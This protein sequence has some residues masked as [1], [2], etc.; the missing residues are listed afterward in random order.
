YNDE[1]T[2]SYSATHTGDT[3]Y[4]LDPAIKDEAK[5]NSLIIQEKQARE[6]GKSS[7]GEAD[8][9][10]TDNSAALESYSGSPDAPSSTPLSRE[11]G[12]ERL[13]ENGSLRDLAISTMD[14]NIKGKKFWNYDNLEIKDP[15]T[16]D[17][18]WKYNKEVSEGTNIYD[19][20]VAVCRYYNMG[21]MIPVIWG[22]VGAESTFNPFDKNPESVAT[23][24][25]Q[26]MHP[27]WKTFI[28]AAKK[29]RDPFASRI[30]EGQ[31]GVG[32]EYP[33]TNG[34]RQVNL[35][36]YRFPPEQDYLNYS[37]CNPFLNIY[38]TIV[39]TKKSIEKYKRDAG[40]DIR[41]LEVKEQLRLLYTMHHDGH[42]GGI[43]MLRF[44]KRLESHGIDTKN[45]YAVSAFIKSGSKEADAALSILCGDR[46]GKVNGKGSTQEYRARNKTDRFLNTW[47][48]TGQ[49]AAKYAMRGGGIKE[50]NLASGGNGKT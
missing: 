26:P 31:Y 50:E 12:R 37:R 33:D 29:S 43:A 23:G 24:L 48:E 47:Y 32:V 9:S 21:D 19:F 10:Q 5:L 14:Q 42:A 22:T 4:V 45:R 7:Y 35:S 40:I 27:T 36:E 2:G 44:L 3:V 11:Q 46:N 20:S 49:T 1:A 17:L 8:Y 18:I 30:L 39:Y 38:H 6:E 15:G 25:G 13:R 28:P 16:G 41:Q 34:K